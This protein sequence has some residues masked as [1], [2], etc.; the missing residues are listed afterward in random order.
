MFL[1]RARPENRNGW[2]CS[3]CS[4]SCALFALGPGLLHARQVALPITVLLQPQVVKKIPRIKPGVVTIRKY[5]FHR[6]VAYRFDGLDVHILLPGLHPLL[7][8]SMPAH[9]GRGRIDTQH[10]AGKAELF[11]V[12]EGDFKF[13]GLLVQ[14][15]FGRSRGSG[16]QASHDA[17]FSRFV[18]IEA[19]MIRRDGAAWRNPPVA[20]PCHIIFTSLKYDALHRQWHQPKGGRQ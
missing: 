9:L 11:A 3:W 8:R 13:A 17:S 2:C 1:P 10:F 12:V 14:L 15:D 20:W 5:Q 16:G 19:V 7:A 18:S 4:V 6:I